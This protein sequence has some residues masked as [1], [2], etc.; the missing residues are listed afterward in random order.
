MALD[1]VLDKPPCLSNDMAAACS[2]M[3]VQHPRASIAALRCT[4]RR[5]TAVTNAAPVCKE[6]M[7]QSAYTHT[8][9]TYRRTKAAAGAVACADKG[10]IVVGVDEQCAIGNQCL[11]DDIALV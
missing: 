4:A 10:G 2:D 1:W 8:H 7:V 3:P 5:L 6:Y 9:T 11:C